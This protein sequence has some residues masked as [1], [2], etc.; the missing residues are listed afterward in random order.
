MNNGIKNAED[1]SKISGF[2][3]DKIEIIALYLEF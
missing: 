3:V 2:P 1:L